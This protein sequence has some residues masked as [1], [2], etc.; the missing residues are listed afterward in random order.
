MTHICVSELTI[1]GSDNG[2]SPGRR[3]AIIWNNVGILLIGPLG[4][5]FSEISIGIQTFSFKKM[6]LKVSSVK[7]CE[8]EAMLSRPQCVK[9]SVPAAMVSW[10]I[11]T[12]LFS[13]FLKKN[14]NM[15]LPS[16]KKFNTW[17]RTE[18]VEVNYFTMRYLQNFYETSIYFRSVLH[19]GSSSSAHSS[20][21][22]RGWS[23]KG[24]G[25]DHVVPW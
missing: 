4:T 13:T 11:S 14:F 23:W 24:N 5:N 7:I 25:A 12:G 18:I 19:P 2:L 15:S 10:L 20:T 6:R 16:S 17:W 21:R 9:A 8:M 1:T 22:S 3:Q